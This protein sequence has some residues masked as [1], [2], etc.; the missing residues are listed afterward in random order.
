METRNGT[1]TISIE[2]ADSRGV[3]DLVRTLDVDGTIIESIDREEPDLE[4]VFLRL[5]KGARG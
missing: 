3:F 5:I 2:F 1:T 4:Q